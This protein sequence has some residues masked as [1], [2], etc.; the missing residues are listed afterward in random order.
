MCAR[1]PPAERAPLQQLRRELLRAAVSDRPSGGAPRQILHVG[2]LCRLHWM[3]GRRKDRRVE[4]HERMPSPASGNG[5][6]QRRHG[7]ERVKRADC[8]L[9]TE[10]SLGTCEDFTNVLRDPRPVV[11]LWIVQRI[12]A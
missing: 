1:N 7:G 2:D 12:F 3:T 8:W 9:N 5:V 10:V 4:Q 6:E 11:L